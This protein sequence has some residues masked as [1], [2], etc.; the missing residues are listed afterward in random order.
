MKPVVLIT[1]ASTGFGRLLA[2]K[3]ARAEYRTFATMRD[4]QERNREEAQSLRAAAPGVQVVELDVTDEKSIARAVAETL[5]EAGRIDV[6]VN[7]AGIG[8]AG[9]TEGYT[10]EQVHRIFDVNV[11]GCV[12]V[13][14]AVLPS[15]RAQKSGLLVHVTSAAGRLALPYLG[16]YVA[17]KWALEGL[18]ES[19]RLE[20]APLGID[21]VVVEPGKYKTEI[22]GRMLEPA[23][24]LSAAYGAGDLSR[25]FLENFNGDLER[26]SPDPAEVIDAIVRLM[27]TPRGQR[28]F[29]TLV[30]ADAQAL[31][32]YNAA[33]DQIR[34]AVMTVLGVE[35]LLANDRAAA[36]GS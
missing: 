25:V 28:P 33:A 20:L 23:E 34:E 6:V 21:S 14:R 11:L 27:Q 18:A 35:G 30:G 13:N 36:A 9:L 17:S 19:Y 24:N 15:M 1:G 10:P 16:P 2:E 26:R 5:R 7:N 8:N 29:R 22:F 31:A 12:R 4:L 32:G 3:L